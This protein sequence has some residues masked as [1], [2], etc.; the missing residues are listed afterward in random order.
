MAEFQLDDDQLQ[1]QETMRK[2][3]AQELRKRARESDE[4][5]VLPEEVLDKIW[6]LGVCAQS[7]PEDFGGFGMGRSAVTGAIMAEELAW[8]D[9]S[10]AVAALSPMLM[11]VPILEYGTEAQKEEWLPEFCGET[12]FPATAA[13]VE[14][15]VTFDPFQLKTTF[16]K[17]GDA[18]VLNGA[19][20]MVPL[21]DRAKHILVFAQA[22][23]GSGPSSVQAIVVDKDTSG[24]RVG[25]P[26]SYMGLRCCPLFP[27]TFEGCEVPADRLVGASRGIHYPRLLNLSRATLS[28]MAVGVSRASWE[29]AR[30][31]AKERTAFGE[32][33][34]SR[35]AIAFMLAEMAMEIDAMR[36]MAWRTAWRLDR[37]EDA[38]RDATLAKMYCSDQAM[39]IVDYGVQIL[40]GHG[41]IREH[42]V[43][44]WF[45]NGR[46][47]KTAEGLALV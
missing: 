24:M 31:Y 6:E 47:I 9:L 20:C 4:A 14:P 33:I 39:K 1:I 27:V 29:Y 36:L 23:T 19:K 46:G 7:I 12:F 35:Q 25:K 43:E 44:L 30:D 45:R 38:T 13:L 41:Y 40:G 11:A 10:L 5:G 28:A 34:A 22:A 15:R 3:A 17:S 2:F 21:A 32:P 16:A 8:G 26:E 37:E 42:P 18:I